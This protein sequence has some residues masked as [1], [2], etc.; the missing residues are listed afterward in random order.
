M[1]SMLPATSRSIDYSPRDVVDLSAA[2]VKA[3]LQVAAL[4]TELDVMEMQGRELAR[5]ME[6]HK[7]Q[8]VDVR[9]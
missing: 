2:Q 7:G 9:V 5:L 1:V 8:Y 3:Q 6:P 4:R